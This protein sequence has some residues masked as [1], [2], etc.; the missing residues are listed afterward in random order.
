MVAESEDEIGEFPH[1]ACEIVVHD[2]VVVFARVRHFALRIGEAA[3][4][5]LFCLGAAGA[6]AAFQFFEGRRHDEDELACLAEFGGIGT[7]VYADSLSAISNASPISISNPSLLFYTFVGFCCNFLYFLLCGI[8]FKKNKLVAAIAILFGVSLLLSLIS[9]AF[10]PSFVNNISDSL[11]ETQL[12][13]WVVRM[14]NISV[15][16]TCIT[17]VGLAWGIWRR[18]KTIQH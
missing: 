16:V 13:E 4:D 15:A 17:T 12:A 11:D 8:C 9:G 1:G 14:M 3:K 6:E 7:I 18:I 2:D 10:L 5:G